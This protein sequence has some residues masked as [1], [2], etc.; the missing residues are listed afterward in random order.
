MLELAAR[1]FAEQNLVPSLHLDGDELAV[2]AILAL[3]DGDYLALLGLFLGGVRDDD[4]TLGPLF[5]LDA[6]DENSIPQRFDFHRETAASLAH[7]KWVCT[8]TVPAFGK[9]IT[10]RD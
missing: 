1:V 8:G 6:L 9:L 7:E 2:V 10:D 5:F 4:S 3:A